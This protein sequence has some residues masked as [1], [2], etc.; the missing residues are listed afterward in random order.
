MFS[1]PG[2]TVPVLAGKGGTYSTDKMA[3]LSL[4]YYGW[5]AW[6]WLSVTIR[7]LLLL[8]HLP[9]TPQIQS[10]CQFTCSHQSS[11]FNHGWIILRIRLDPEWY[12]EVKG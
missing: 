9:T 6:P 7:G 3:T 5:M 11:A 8:S 12:N 4:V 10:Y 2:Q 1:A